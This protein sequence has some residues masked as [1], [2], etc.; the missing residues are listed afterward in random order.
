MAPLLNPTRMLRAPATTCWLVT[1][2]PRRSIT[3]PEPSDWTCWAVIACYPGDGERPP[4]VEVVDAGQVKLVGEGLRR[5]VL[6][7]LVE[8]P[9]IKA[10]RV[11]VNQGGDLWY[12]V[13]HSMPV[14]VGAPL[15]A[16]AGSLKPA[17]K[18]ASRGTFQPCRRNASAR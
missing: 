18:A 2:L 4:S 12:T 14:R 9:K 1:M 16:I 15:V 8:Y 3:K 10:V 17:I 6:D 5:W 13:F 7:K 11:E